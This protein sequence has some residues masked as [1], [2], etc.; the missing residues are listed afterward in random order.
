MRKLLLRS[1][2]ISN[3]A[4]TA[5]MLPIVEAVLAQ[6]INQDRIS[7]PCRKKPSVIVR[8]LSRMKPMEDDPSARLTEPENVEE[9]SA[10]EGFDL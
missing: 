6:L 9:V 10:G 7:G 4:T 3:T 5:M 2:W 1:M 8:K